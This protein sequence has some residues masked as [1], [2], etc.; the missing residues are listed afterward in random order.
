MLSWSELM[1]QGKAALQKEYDDV[2]ATGVPAIKAG[3]ETWGAQVLTEQA[4]A[5]KAELKSAVVAI[6]KNPP[7][8]PGSIGESFSNLFKE[9][10]GDVAGN[11][12][13]LWIVAG[14][15]ALVVLGVV[16]GRK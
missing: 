7:P 11:K 5:S 1:D 8:A 2:V 13:G 6:S 3:L 16:L 4:N 9:V 14:V 15:G 10:G 12:Y